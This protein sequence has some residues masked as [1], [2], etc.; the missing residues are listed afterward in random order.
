MAKSRQ[1]KKAES[2]EGG[3]NPRANA[4]SSGNRDCQL[5]TGDSHT[6]PGQHTASWQTGSTLTVKR[7]G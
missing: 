4:P 5:S 7:N 3:R 2:G 1:L 6:Y